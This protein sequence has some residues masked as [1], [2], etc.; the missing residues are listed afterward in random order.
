MNNRIEIL[1]TLFLQSL[2]IL[3]SSFISEI[4]IIIYLWP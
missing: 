4:E 3:P 1:Q 2:N